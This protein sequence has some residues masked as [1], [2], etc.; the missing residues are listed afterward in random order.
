MSSTLSS[1]TVGA[2]PLKALEPRPC[3]GG[4]PLPCNV[5]TVAM[6]ARVKNGIAVTQPYKFERSEP[7]TDSESDNENAQTRVSQSATEW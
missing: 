1:R 6:D 2:C 7:D 4:G 5:A 3:V